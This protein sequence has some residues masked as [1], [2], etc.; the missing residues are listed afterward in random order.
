MMNVK[1]GSLVSQFLFFT[2]EVTKNYLL[3]KDCEA[4]TSM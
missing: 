4:K 3:I 2:E 1:T